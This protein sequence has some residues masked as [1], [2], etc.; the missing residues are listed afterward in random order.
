MP[1]T[2]PSVA[3]GDA[4]TVRAWVRAAGGRRTPRH[5]HAP[6]RRAC[7]PGSWSSPQIAVLVSERRTLKCAVGNRSASVGRNDRWRR[8]QQTQRGS[9]KRV[10]DAGV[11][12]VCR[13]RAPE[14]CA[15]VRGRRRSPRSGRRGR[16]RDTALAQMPLEAA[17]HALEHAR[18]RTSR[19]EPP[20]GRVGTAWTVSLGPKRLVRAICGCVD[21][22]RR[23]APCRGGQPCGR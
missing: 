12:W 2:R 9:S 15:P 11:R 16:V 21:V 3:A 6:P 8:I 4:L 5:R 14:T 17:G 1:V 13:S 23:L 20:R 7:R 10:P 22:R 19:L 18:I